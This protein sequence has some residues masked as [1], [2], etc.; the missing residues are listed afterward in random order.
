MQRQYQ[1]PKGSSI[2]TRMCICALTCSLVGRINPSSHTNTKECGIADH[3][4]S[5]VCIATAPA[6]RAQQ[7][8]FFIAA[9]LH[10]R[11]RHTWPIASSLI[12]G[13]RGICNEAQEFRRRRSHVTLSAAAAAAAACGGNRQIAFGARGGANVRQGLL[14]CTYEYV[15]GFRP[16]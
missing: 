10:C 7:R 14:Y 5:Q 6:H 8:P 4:L 13:I 11:F 9:L 2:C 3:N 16:S 12:F 15:R 1:F